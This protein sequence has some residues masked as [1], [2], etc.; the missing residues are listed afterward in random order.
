MKRLAAG[1]FGALALALA[2]VLAL[3]ACGKKE[4][5]PEPPRPV[6]TM[7]VAHDGEA[8]GVTYTGEVRSRYETA[9]A[10]RIPGKVSARLVDA[11]ARV[12]AGD[13]LARLDPADTGSSLAAAEAQLELADSDAR[14]YRD[15]R[16]KNFVSQSALD[17]KETAFRSA[18]A[19]AELARNQRA[20]TELRA[21]RDG[22]VDLVSVEPGQVVAAGQTVMRH[23]SD[24]VLDVVVAIPE[25]RLAMVR[26]NQSAEISLWAD[27]KAQYRGVLRELAPVADA[28]T[29][30]YAGRVL[31]QDPDERIRL[32]MTAKVTFPPEKSGQKNRST[33]SVPS[34]AVFQKDGKP[35]VWIVRDDHTVVLR[36]VSVVRFGETQA[37]LGDGLMPG[38][39]IVIAGVHK[40]T[41]GEKINVVAPQAPQ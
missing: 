7:V 28:V 36:P 32:G 22:V 11:G 5:P 14:R 13:V 26:L 4:L 10:F 34:A 35:A 12:R 39:R 27:E 18:K 41:Q 31:L 25:S 9:L 15:L 8:M 38:E 17:A 6:L 29:R 16:A 21:A 20:Y 3:G 1:C 19:Q 24:K 37:E 23:V 40:L 2:S 30:T 33:S